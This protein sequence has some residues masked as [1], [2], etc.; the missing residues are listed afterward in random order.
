MNIWGKTLF[1]GQSQINGEVKIVEYF[2]GNRRLFASKFAQ[3]RTLDKNGR[4][5][6]CWDAFVDVARGLDEGS[7][8]LILG[9]AAG[10]GASS[11]RQT[12]PKVEIDGVEID[13]LMVELGNKY[14]D[15]EKAKVNIFL[16]DAARFVEKANKKYD[17]IFV[18]VFVG[19][20]VPSFV[21]RSDF[22]EK[23]KALLKPTS[24]VIFNK[25]YNNLDEAK[26]IK[27]FFSKH[28]KITKEEHN[29]NR[30]I[31][32]NLILVGEPA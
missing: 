6:F 25:I 10:T 1:K 17:L 4:S 9:L 20:E 21:F 18:D 2:G 12:H 11:L 30:R 23:L 15:L 14:F 29:P 8:I 22:I 19:G 27:S 5:E 24:K 13:P 7:S 16:E 32:G 3:S 31:P 28:F 26:E